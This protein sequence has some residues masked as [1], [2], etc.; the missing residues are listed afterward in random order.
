MSDPLPSVDDTVGLPELPPFNSPELL[1]AAGEASL[2]EAGEAPLFEPPTNFAPAG[3]MSLFEAGEAP[4]FELPTNFAPAGEMSLFE[5]PAGEASLFEPP[6]NFPPAGGGGGRATGRSRPS[7]SRGRGRPPTGRGRGRTSSGRGGSSRQGTGRGRGRS[8]RSTSARGL[9]RAAAR[10]ASLEGP[11]PESPSHNTLD[12]VDD[13]VTAFPAPGRVPAL[14]AALRH[15]QN[16]RLLR[17][18]DQPNF[19]FQQTATQYMLKDRFKSFV[20][21]FRRKFSHKLRLHSLETSEVNIFSLLFGQAIDS[22][23]EFTNESLSTRN[24]QLMSP[25]EFR[26]FLGTMLLSSSFNASVE[27]MWDMMRSVSNSKCM[28]KQRYN[29][30]LS[31]LRGFDVSKRMVQEVTGSWC[32]QRN[33]LRNLHFLEKRIFERTVEFFF[34]PETSTA[35]IDD[36]LT[37]SKGEDVETKIVTERK[38]GK[39]GPVTDVVTDCYFQV[40][41]GIR[42]RTVGESQMVNVQKLLVTL[43]AVGADYRAAD[44][45]PI[46]ACDRGYGKLSFINML[47]ELNFKVITIANNLGSEHPFVGQSAIDAFQQ[48]VRRAVPDLGSE[49]F[50]R[51]LQEHNITDF[52]V[53]D[54]DTAL[55]GPQV[56][57]AQ[58]NDDN[59]LYAVAVRDIFDKKIAQKLLRFFLYGF[60]DM[61][62]FT[63]YWIV[64]PKKNDKMLLNRLFCEHEREPE[65]LRVEEALQQHCTPLTHAQRTAEWFTLRQFHISATMAARVLNRG[66]DITSAH[67]L[68]MLS[69]SWFS[70]V[71]STPDMVAGT[72]NEPAILSALLQHE[73]VVNLFECGLLESKEVPWLAASPDAIAELELPGSDRYDLAVVE[74]KTKVSHDRIAN[75]RRIQA[76]Y[77]SLWIEAEVG[78]EIW[79]DC[80]EAEHQTQLMVQMAVTK[81][82][83]CCYVVAK[84]GFEGSQGRILYIVLGKV[85]HEAIGEFI[86]TLHDCCNDLLSPFYPD[87][88]DVHATLRFPAD[89]A[90]DTVQTIISRWYF[91]KLMR[92]YVMTEYNNP[93][94]GFPATSLFKTTFQAIYNTLKGGLD[95]N[96]QQYCTIKPTVKTSFETKY[97]IRLILAIVTNSWRGKQ[98]LA[99]PTEGVP[100]MLSYRKLLSNH[101]PTLRDFT[102]KLAMGLIDSSDDPYFQNVLFSRSQSTMP[103]DSLPDIERDPATLGQRLEQ[104]TWPQRFKL[105]KF[106]RDPTF[107]E[108][109]LTSNA[110]FQHQCQK[111]RA[112]TSRKKAQC[113]LCLDGQTRYGC[114]V[115]NVMLCRLPRNNQTGGMNCFT[116]WHSKK[117]LMSESKRIVENNPSR[118]RQQINQRKAVRRTRKRRREANNSS[119]DATTSDEEQKQPSDRDEG[120]NDGEGNF[121]DTNSEEAE[122]SEETEDEVE[123]ATEDGSSTEVDSTSEES[124]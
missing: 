20:D 94:R 120:N 1:H 117:D 55:M 112:G 92:D 47:K 58:H 9:S 83:Y 54:L 74:I 28:S 35:V 39:E 36:E 26:L 61:D 11:L 78:G 51:L 3:E 30:V 75:S 82:S 27:T 49:G 124:S 2:F 123:T 109:R 67:V 46:V 114:S 29:Q 121:T 97:V 70:R 116:I 13:D 42:L 8:G 43:S 31:N 101:G 89:L 57:I 76:R 16:W 50:S 33:K 108:L 44:S 90:E 23:L 88:E 45:G 7:T 65:T 37:A 69:K 122:D 40:I 14:P 17:I 68:E 86:V 64:V 110:Q 63:G 115:C 106:S 107:I 102:H 91:F 53:H 15:Q 48:K 19:S 71:R 84:A 6:S 77:N 25:S 118:R 66:E 34:D 100:G 98:L 4:L 22:I 85:A 10:A 52:V 99:N 111:I 56:S 119:D 41:L 87:M 60:H 18:D 73:Y 113:A 103:T 24:L 105:Q 38:A 93:P 5:A 96:T 21:G 81:C 62:F 80:V 59:L 79:N 72:K 32:D 12:D 95:N 104:A